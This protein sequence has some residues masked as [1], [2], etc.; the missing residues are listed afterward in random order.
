MKIPTVLHV[1]CDRQWGGGQ[2]QALY[3]H[4][5][6]LSQGY[7]SGFICTPKSELEHRLQGHKASYHCIRFRGEADL[8]AAIKLARYAKRQGYQILHLHTS[9]ALSWGLMAKFFYPKLKL[10]ASR[11]V[12]VRIGQNLLSRWKYT[13]AGLN[14]IVAISDKIR[15]MLVQ[16]GVPEAKIRLIYSGVDTHKFDLI[17]PEADYRRQWQVPSD[18]IIVGTVA[19]FVVPKDYP[20]FISAAAIAA[21]SNARL[22][23]VAVGD[24]TLLKTMQELADQ[25]GLAGRITFTGFQSCVGK[26]LKAF[27]LFVLASKREGLGTSILDAMSLGLPVIGTRAGGIK[28]I[29][30]D[31]QNGILVETRDSA[32][33]ADAILQLAADIQ[34]RKRLGSGALLS[35]Q[36]F[37]QKHMVDANIRLYES[38]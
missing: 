30:Q 16:D 18:A 9:H 23:F 21:Q 29:I 5:G 8:W 32:A 7:T 12:A 37:D 14:M 3:L 6:L 1:D 35:V 27:D 4:L 38:L 10:I 24:G 15:Q 13:G 22:H 36:D 28:E 2:Q 34:L 11:R 17:Q 26:H 19:A 31:N 33:L 20:N 25:S